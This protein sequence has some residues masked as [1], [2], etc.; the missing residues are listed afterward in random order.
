MKTSSRAAPIR[1]SDMPNRIGFIEQ[2]F[3]LNSYL[4]EQFFKMSCSQRTVI[5]ISVILFPKQKEKNCSV[6]CVDAV[7]CCVN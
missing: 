5:S 4:K 2:F 1:I 7:E 3:D 6:V